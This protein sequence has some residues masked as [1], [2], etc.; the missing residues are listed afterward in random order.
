MQVYDSVQPF[1]ELVINQF[2][3]NS[4]L[5]RI[6]AATKEVP[7]FAGL[8]DEQTKRLTTAFT[9]RSFSPGETVFAHGQPVD[10]LHIILVGSVSLTKENQPVAELSTGQCLGETS[11]L[12]DDRR[13]HSLTAT[14]KTSVETA[15]VSVDDLLRTIRRNPDIGVIIYRNLAAD[16]SAK[17]SQVQAGNPRSETTEY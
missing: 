9:T 14:A 5:P 2:K 4:V 10:D 16:V 6:A 15:V 12:Y 11:L 8:N 7:T 17:L 3:S 1:A 13:P